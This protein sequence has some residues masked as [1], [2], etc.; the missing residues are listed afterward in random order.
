MSDLEDGNLVALVVYEVDDS[1]LPLP[2]A[3]AVNVSRE[4]FRT[5]RA[6][7]DAQRFNP[8]NDSPTIGFCSQGLDFFCG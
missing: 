4:L 5:L 6:G 7:I 3:I 1:V 8:L 2:H